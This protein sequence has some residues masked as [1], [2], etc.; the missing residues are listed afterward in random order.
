VVSAERGQLLTVCAI[1][2]AIG[3][4]IPPVFIFPRARMHDW[5]ML[6]APEGSL[7][8]ANCP[9]SGW[10]TGALFVHVLEHIKKYTRCS[11]EDPILLLLDNHESHCTLDGIMYSRDNGIVLCTF[12][13]HCTHK[14]QPLDVGVLG[15]FK[16]KLAQ[17]QQSWLWSNPGKTI[18][19]HNLPGIIREAFDNSFTRTNI[20]GAFKKTGIWPFDISVFTEEDF[21]CSTVTNRPQPTNTSMIESSINP[22]NEQASSFTIHSLSDTSLPVDETQKKK[23]RSMEPLTLTPESVRPYPKAP[24]RKDTNRGR[25]RGKSRILTSTPE[26]NLIAA[27]TLQRM[28]KNNNGTKT[29]RQSKSEAKKRLSQIQ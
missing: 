11:K 15:P 18:T 2:S 1:V 3:N 20:T 21:Q 9:A 28:E 24:E 22:L 8:L 6:N 14:L 17:K 5:L 10:M 12:P 7:G 16:T 29:M 23:K 27:A 13:P 26:K 25:K 19:I 4:V